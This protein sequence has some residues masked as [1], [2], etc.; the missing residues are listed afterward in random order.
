MPSFSAEELKALFELDQHTL[1][2]THDLLKC[3]CCNTVDLYTEDDLKHSDAENSNYK[4]KTDNNSD[5][6]NIDNI[7]KMNMDMDMNMDMGMGSCMDF[8]I[9]VN[10]NQED[11][12]DNM[13]KEV[14]A[15]LFGASTSSSS[16]DKNNNNSNDDN[17]NN[18]IVN[19]TYNNI[20]ATENKNKNKN[21]N[22]RSKNESKTKTKT[23]NKNKQINQLMSWHHYFPTIQNINRDHIKDEALILTVD[24]LGKSE[25]QKYNNKNKNIQQEDDNAFG[26]ASI[27][28]RISC[29]FYTESN[30]ESV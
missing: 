9:G 5:N 11:M 12:I 19:N 14:P 15:D 13:L 20:K 23:K 24:N 4:E 2:D 7:D 30:K 21:K 17:N 18:N 1:S 16:I 26:S 27:D 3:D 28:N 8:G 29:I 6:N 10:A 25:S 22:E